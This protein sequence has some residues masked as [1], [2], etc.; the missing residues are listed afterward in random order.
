MRN[1][2]NKMGINIFFNL[3]SLLFIIPFILVLSISLSSEQSIS[4]QGYSLLP[5]MMDTA[6]YRYVF[7]NPAQII[8]SYKITVLVTAIGTFLGVLIMAMI[9]YPLS[10]ENFKYR[11]FI[12]FVVFFTMLFSGG[13]VSSY[14]LNTQYLHLTDTIWALILPTLCNGFH[15][16]LLRT[17]FQ[18]IPVSI[19]ESAKLDGAG[20]I[21]IFFKM[22]LPLAKP[23]IAT[24]AFMTAMGRWNDWFGALLYIRSDRLMPL[25]YLL[26]RILSD[27]NFLTANMDNIPSGM[28]DFSNIPNESARMAMLV[29]AAGPMLFVFP[30]F[31]RYFVAGLTVGSIKG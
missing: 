6:G 30:F 12:M 23:A 25:Q 28:I 10:R 2:K 3:M 16:V 4:Q 22:I 1:T 21:L 9:A 8:D 11:K 13:L 15:I 31:Q 29:I 19:A 24:V 27:L 7:A 20:E 26:Q 17:Y 18:S 5:K 14:I